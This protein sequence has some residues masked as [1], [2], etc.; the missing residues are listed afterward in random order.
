MKK[1]L[2]G[3]FVF[4]LLFGAFGT[5]TQSNEPVVAE[6]ATVQT[7]RRVY[8]KLAGGWDNNGHMF[9][10]YWGGDAG[11]TWG[12]LPEMT[13]VLSDYYSGLFYYDLPV[14]VT[15]FMVSA[16]AGGTVAEKNKSVDIT[17]AD[18]LVGSN[19]KAATIGAWVADD[20]KRT[21]TAEDTLPMSSLQAAAV[22]NHIDSCSSS[23]A[24]G[25]NAWPQLYD[26]FI[27]PSTLEGSTVVTDNF[28]EDTT[29]TNKKAWLE[30]KYN[31]D[32]GIPSS[33]VIT[34]LPDNKS[35]LS[36]LLLG[37]IGFTVLGGIFYLTKKKISA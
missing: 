29:I 1:G 36:L 21:F 30:T 17:V 34:Y 35:L 28:G 25:Y 14:D 7:H 12:S 5:A 26:L 10:H 33:G 37:I 23:Y 19:Y 11:T 16:Y 31:E 20:T 18:L 27:A 15:T 24:G 3:L 6:A 2:L 22:L 13:Y 9:I 8:A 32:Q 4:G